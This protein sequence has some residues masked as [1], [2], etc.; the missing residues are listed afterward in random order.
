MPTGIL[1]A[2]FKKI[3][4][5]AFFALVLVSCA[6]EKEVEPQSNLRELT[7]IVVSKADN[8]SFTTDGF[9]FKKND[10]FY[11]TLPA[12]SDLTKVKLSVTISPKA[13]LTFNGMPLTGLS[14]IFDLSKTTKAIVT[15][16]SGTAKVYTVLAQTGI[17]DLDRLIYEFKEN[18]SIPGVSYAISKTATSE[19]VYKSGIG[20]SDMENQVRTK[21]DH[22]FRLG[23]ISKQFTSIS[24]M[25]LIQ[26]GKFNVSSK[27]F[28][29]DGILKDDFSNISDRAAT[30]TVRNLLDHSTGW[31]SSPDP[32]F[33]GSFSG[34]TLDQRIN[35]VLSSAQNE[36]GTKFSYYNMGYGILGKVIEKTS[37]KKFET[38]M[39]EV[40]AE[41]GVTDIHVG[42]DRGGKRTN[43]VV[44]YSQEGTNGYAN[45]MEVIAAAGGVIA[46]TEQMLKLLPYIDGK[47]NV[48]DILNPEIRTL[49]LTSS[50]ANTYAL[51]WRMNHRL[52]PGA[53]YHGGNLSGTGT[54]WVMG[55]EYNVVILC[56]SRSYKAGFDDEMYYISEKLINQAATL[57]R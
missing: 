49:M 16:E 47:S 55:P 53:W 28:G 50:T 14:G 5:V 39:K 56:N 7:N 43:E 31:E 26:Q 22:L 51:G 17:K 54:F 36:P 45:D 6:K 37:G 20:F 35:Y 30:V 1:P 12:G 46:S 3:M 32:M 23:S 38:Y 13:S 4:A 29:A 2:L 42:K 15:S 40:L 11:I 21:P 57:F 34:Q 18:Y 27:V 24:V 44:Y 10:N 8:P 25:K 9:V 48:P 33:T 19:I 52:F 41:A